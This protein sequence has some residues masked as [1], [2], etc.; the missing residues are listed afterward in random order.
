MSAKEKR[1]NGS[2]ESAKEKKGSGDVTKISQAMKKED[3]D[4]LRTVG[5]WRRED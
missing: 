2:N 4:S 5:A 3:E 1:C